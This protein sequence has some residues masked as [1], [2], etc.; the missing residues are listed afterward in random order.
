M[1][2]REYHGRKDLAA[3]GRGGD[4]RLAHVM[5]GEIMVPPVISEDLRQRIYA[6]MEA[7]GVSPYDHTVGSGMSINPMTG[8]PEFGLGKSFKKAFKS[9]KKVASVAAPLVGFIPGLQPLAAAGLGAGLGALS[10][11]GV[12]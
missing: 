10:G 6:E 11:G 2:A 3:K 1:T 9:I 7:A 4:T 5:D 12:S 8:L